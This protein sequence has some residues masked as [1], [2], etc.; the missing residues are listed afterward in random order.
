MY[1]LEAVRIAR[2]SKTP[3]SRFESCLAH[4]INTFMKLVP[5][6]GLMGVKSDYTLVTPSGRELFKVPSW[7]AWRIQ[8]V[9]HW[10]AQKTWR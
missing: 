5:V 1:A 3:G 2:A 10:I 4:H 8:H 6:I 9:Q 7:A